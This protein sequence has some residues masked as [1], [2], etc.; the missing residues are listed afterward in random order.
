MICKS[1]GK[2]KKHKALGLCIV[3]YGKQYYKRY[4]K[5]NRDKIINRAIIHNQINKTKRNAMNRIHNC[6]HGAKPMSENKVCSSFLGVHIAEQVLSKVFKD[7]EIMPPNNPGYDF[8][9]NKG[10]KIDVK[11]ACIG[12]NNTHK[13]QWS[14]YINKNKIADYFLCIAFNNREDLNPLHIW[15]MPAKN[16]NDHKS[17]SISESTILKWTKYT[18]NIDKVAACCNHMKQKKNQENKHNQKEM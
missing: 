10:K 3:C 2:E 11:S 15:L 5:A 8:I 14:F 18:L 1:C 17:I 7:V 9:C 4:Y 12:K 16:I 13:R 6:N